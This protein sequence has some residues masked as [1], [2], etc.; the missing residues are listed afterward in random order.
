MTDQ[1]YYKIQYPFKKAINDL[2]K[3]DIESTNPDN[4]SENDREEIDRF[5]E[6]WEESGEES[7]R[8]LLDRLKSK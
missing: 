3:V 6:I 8:S 2:K 7:I 1:I 5:I 4:F